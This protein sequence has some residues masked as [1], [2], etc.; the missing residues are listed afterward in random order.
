MKFMS[1]ER[2]FGRRGRKSAK[3]RPA[4]RRY[5]RLELEPL[6]AREL[7]NNDTPFVVRSASMPPNGSVLS[8]PAPVI[9][10]TFSENVVQAEAEN[11]NAY[12]LLN[13]SNQAVPINSVRY[14]PLT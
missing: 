9:A 8:N 4:R 12:R 7:L 1:L 13:S 10:V 2:L 6:E 14:N 11:P 5:R 3:A